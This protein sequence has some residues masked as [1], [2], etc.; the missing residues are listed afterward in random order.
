M[1]TPLSIPTPEEIRADI[2]ARAAELRAKRRLLRLA[3][4]AQ[5]AAAAESARC[6]QKVPG[7]REARHGR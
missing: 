7:T 5:T 4:A 3:E 1:D 2:R 6:L